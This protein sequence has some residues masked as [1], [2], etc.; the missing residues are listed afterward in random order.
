MADKVVE[1]C[2]CS[3]AL[4]LP[5]FSVC[6]KLLNVVALEGSDSSLVENIN[7]LVLPIA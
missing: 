3:C 6:G 5:V 1:S 7:A 2:C 4:E